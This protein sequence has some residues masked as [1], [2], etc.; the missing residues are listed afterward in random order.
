MDFARR[1]EKARRRMQPESQTL[2]VPD[3]AAILNVSSWVAYDL[4]RRGEWPTPVI[5]LG[6][7]VL[8]P[9]APFERLL[10]GQTLKAGWP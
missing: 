9:K 8:V 1:S 7:R 6:R 2:T 3:A 10:A 5:R 4:I